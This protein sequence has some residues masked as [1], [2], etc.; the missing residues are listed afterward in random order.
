M[1]WDLLFVA[2]IAAVVALVFYWVTWATLPHINGQETLWESHKRAFREYCES[3]LCLL[4]VFA[5]FGAWAAL[6]VVSFWAWG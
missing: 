3:L 2:L 1:L 6:F 5:Y 4:C